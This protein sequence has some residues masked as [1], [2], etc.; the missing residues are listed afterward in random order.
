MRK[1]KIWLRTTMYQNRFFFFLVSYQEE[2]DHLCITA[3]KIDFLMFP[4]RIWKKTILLVD[5]I[6]SLSNRRFQL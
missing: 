1:I 6:L 2:G 5:N 3:S 4:K